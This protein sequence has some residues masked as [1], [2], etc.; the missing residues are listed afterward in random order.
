MA[1]KM[2]IGDVARLAGVSTATVWRV[3]NDK[4]DVDPET[5][6]R[7][8]S[9]LV[10]YH[11]L[12]R[13]EGKPVAGHRGTAIGV[14]VPSL[15]WAMIPPI[16]S[17]IGHIVEQTPRELVL[18]NLSHKQ[19][20]AE[21]IRH[22]VATKQIDGLIAAYPD[23]VTGLDEA[24]G[25][26]LRVSQQLSHLYELGLPVVVI[27]DQTAHHDTPWISADNRQGALEVVRH[28]IRLGHR[29]IAHITGPQK[30]L[31]A[32]ERLAGYRA[33]LDEAGLPADRTLEV[34]GDFTAASGWAGAIYLLTL[35]E[36]PTAIFAAN[37]DI[38]GGVLVAV[39]QHG[40]QAPRDMA[41]AGFDDAG[42]SASTQPPLTSA[43]Q[44]FY[45]M[46]RWAAMQLMSMLETP[47]ARTT[48]KDCRVR[49][50]RRPF[51]QRTSAGP[52]PASPSH[53]E[54]P[55]E[56]TQRLSSAFPKSNFGMSSDAVP[57][58]ESPSV[59]AATSS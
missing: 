47:G 43:H 6:Q 42:P 33:A 9:F 20:R 27:D 16:L 48:G 37:D 24:A 10:R 57:R 18:Y 35:P 5:R 29:R 22:V 1:A 3:L 12:P 21:I 51:A 31:C 8:L 52:P 19:E 55:I 2:T 54:L 46:G 44:P 59:L 13:A 40:L 26:D 23:G 32:R 38:A 58:D 4:P 28:L 45:D 56:L 7:I 41:V 11:F 39:R 25:E 14:L 49:S 53:I 17:G 15:T 36:P 30:Y 34:V 50:S